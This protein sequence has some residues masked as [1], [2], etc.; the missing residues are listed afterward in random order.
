L[1]VG[2][3]GGKRQYMDLLAPLG[4]V[5]QAGTLSG[6]PLAMAAGMAT[7]GYLQD[8][9]SEVYAQLEA[10]AK[11]IFDGVAAEA[12]KAG[13][14]LCVNRVGAMGT[15]FFQAGPVTNYDEAARSDTAAFGCFHRAMLE[16]GVWL[17]PSQFE[18]AFVSTAHGAAEVEKTFS[19][20]RAA[21]K[22]VKAG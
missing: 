22:A 21:F 4:P 7:I 6:N 9:Q 14:A 16:G 5:Y 8:H 17:P 18:A 15:W 20:A 11:T 13:V 1:P 10:T 3:F 2:V 12:A 19:A